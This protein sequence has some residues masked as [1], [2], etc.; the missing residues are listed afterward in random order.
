M[1]QLQALSASL[2]FHILAQTLTPTEVE[3]CFLAIYGS[4]IGIFGRQRSLNCNFPSRGE[5]EFT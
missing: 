5:S 4:K 1:A 2:F 3:F